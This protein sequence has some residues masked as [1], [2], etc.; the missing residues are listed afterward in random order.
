MANCSLK[1]LTQTY[2]AE[3]PHCGGPGIVFPLPALQTTF[4]FP[5][6]SFFW[7]LGI[8]SSGRLT[9]VHGTPTA[10]RRYGSQQV[11]ADSPGL[12]PHAFQAWEMLTMTNFLLTY[13]RG[14]AWSHSGIYEAF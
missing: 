4:A 11:G 1:A 12:L 13:K 7:I 2:T 8:T 9:T 5:L 14:W 10:H 6:A 3:S